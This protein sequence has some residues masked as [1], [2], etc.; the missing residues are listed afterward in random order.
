MKSQAF[1]NFTD[2]GSFFWFKLH[3]LRM[4]HEDDMHVQRA[5]N[6]Q[7][8]HQLKL[9]EYNKVQTSYPILYK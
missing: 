1:V 5:R 7:E 4:K 6:E 2:R 8:M 9:A 3:E